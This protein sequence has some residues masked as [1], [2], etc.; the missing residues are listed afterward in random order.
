MTHCIVGIC[1]SPGAKIPLV[2]LK[3]SQGMETEISSNLGT[4]CQLDR[5]WPMFRTTIVFDFHSYVDSK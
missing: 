5:T 4:N 1:T 3:E 2:G